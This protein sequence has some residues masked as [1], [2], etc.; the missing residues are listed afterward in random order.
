MDRVSQYV[1]FPSDRRH[2]VALI[3]ERLRLRQHLRSELA[4]AAGRGRSEKCL[5]AVGVI[6]RERPL[7][8]D[9]RHSEGALNLT[10]ARAAVDHELAGEQP[11]T[12]QIVFGVGEDG[13]LPVEVG[14]LAVAA[15]E[16]ELVVEPGAT[17]WEQGQLRLRHTGRDKLRQRRRPVK[18]AR[19][20]SSCAG[21]YRLGSGG[22][23]LS[24]TIQL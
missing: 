7:H 9:L 22:L 15:G 10:G 24:Q 3:E 21:A 13:Q 19:L 2:I 5:A 12:R 1:S 4:A 16:G 8:G 17:G 11:K 6:A 20:N 23:R 14:H 18:T